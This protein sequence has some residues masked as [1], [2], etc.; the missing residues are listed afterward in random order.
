MLPIRGGGRG[1]PLRLPWIGR[2]VVVNASRRKGTAWESV[3]VD[4]VRGNG[5]PHAERRALAGALDRGDIAG[6]PGIVVEA[7]SCKEIKL[8]EFL[9]EA[10]VERDNDR[11]DLGV[12]WIKRRGKT[13]AAHGYVV[14]SGAAFARLAR[15]AG[16][17]LPLP[18]EE[19]S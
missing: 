11:A 8:A 13:S 14:M 12:A 3:I 1:E 15:A 2:E 5:W 19:A 17:G 10:E 16:Y 18:E 4:F 7:K 6:M 9:D